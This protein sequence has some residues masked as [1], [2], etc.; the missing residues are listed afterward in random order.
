M[1][2]PFAREKSFQWSLNIT[3][4][5]SRRADVT[6]VMQQ[7][8]D[9]RI[10]QNNAVVSLVNRIEGPQDVELMLTMQIT[11]IYLGYTGHAISR[12]YLYITSDKII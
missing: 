5:Y 9:L 6:P 11:D 10:G 8:F 2:G 1:S 4:A 12:I 3:S 7:D